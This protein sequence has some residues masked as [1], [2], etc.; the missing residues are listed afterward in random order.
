MYNCWV[1]PDPLPQLTYTFVVVHYP[2][3]VKIQHYSNTGTCNEQYTQTPANSSVKEE[4]V[5]TQVSA[6]KD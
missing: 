3:V 2:E 4:L 5:T 6:I 1:N